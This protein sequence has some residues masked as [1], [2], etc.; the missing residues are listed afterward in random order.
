MAEAAT[1]TLPKGEFARR[2]NVSAGRVSQMIR[3]GKIAPD[4]IEGEGRSAR[5]RVALAMR[6]IGH[7]TDVGQRYGNGLATNLETL[8][9]SPT[10]VESSDS[11]EGDG[12]DFAASPR[13]AARGRVPQP[14]C[15]R[16]RAGGA[17]RLC[18]P[19][20]RQAAV[21]GMAGSMVTVFEGALGDFAQAIA[22]KF[23]LPNRD[24][25]HLLR[26]EFTAV[27]EKAATAME[28]A[29][30]RLPVLIVDERPDQG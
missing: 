7:R 30:E 2:I 10:P 5:I 21:A 17:R 18:S 29:A 15:G 1:E 24:V 14:G 23:E 13:E 16:K 8:T 20:R 26:T 12:I 19:R 27:R 9:R 22:S 28:R 4:A 6:Q 11:R 3:E 25:L